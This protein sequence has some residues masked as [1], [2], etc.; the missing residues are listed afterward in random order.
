MAAL[1]RPSVNQV[2][3]AYV[4]VYVCDYYEIV[5]GLET[6]IALWGV[7]EIG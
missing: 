2:I 1:C 5:A 3:G 4:S 7:L 6:E